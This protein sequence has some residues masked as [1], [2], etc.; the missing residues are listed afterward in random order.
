MSSFVVRFIFIFVIIF[1]LNTIRLFFA[2]RSI[3]KRVEMPSKTQRVSLGVLVFL[4]SLIGFMALLGLIMNNAEMGIVNSVI[5]LIFAALV[6]FVRR[7]YKGFYEETTDSFVLKDE[8]RT[9]QVDYENIVDWVLLPKQIGVLD[10]TQPENKYICVN[11]VFSDPEVLL[12]KLSEMTFSGKFDQ[13]DKSQT[14]DSNREQEFI[15][16]LQKNGYGYLVEKSLK[17]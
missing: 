14:D 7:K 8:Y 4:T 9:F 17:E 2:R 10:K 6:F 5:T 15:K 16:H 1:I 12:K 3:K 11:L 13:T